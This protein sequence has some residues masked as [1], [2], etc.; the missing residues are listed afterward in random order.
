MP[1]R[2]PTL[3]GMTSPWIERVAGTGEIA[4]LRRPMVVARVAAASRNPFRWALRHVQATGST[5]DDLTA[6]EP[7]ASSADPVLITEEQVSGRGRAGRSWAC[8]PG[9]GLMFSSRL[10][11]PEIPIERRGWIGATLGVAI[12]R[13]LDVLTVEP[14]DA[15]LRASLK[16]PNDVLIGGRKCAGILAELTADGVVV[17]AG[18]NVSLLPTELPRPD[19]TSLLL[20]GVAAVDRNVLLAGILDEFGDLLDAW[21]AAGGDVDASGL[22]SGY[23]ALCS[24]LGSTVRLELPGGAAIVGQ[25]VDVDAD[26]AIVVDAGAIRSRYSAGDVVH[27]RSEKPVG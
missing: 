13:A 20:A 6:A 22:R 7:T 18:L 5:N 8:P 11:L 17:G 24:T 3:V 9:A 2:A 16:W 4:E 26:G 15:M 12:V 19:A 23:R 27:L 25:A 10:R 21:R 1:A 14:P